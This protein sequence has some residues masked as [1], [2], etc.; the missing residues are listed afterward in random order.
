MEGPAIHMLRNT[1]GRAQFRPIQASGLV[2]LILLL[3]CAP[4]SPEA[5]L[6]GVYV[7]GS[8]TSGAGVI[9]PA[10]WKGARRIDLPVLDP[11]KEGAALAVA[12]TGTSVHAVGYSTNPSG[13]SVPAHWENGLRRDLPV[14]DPA[15]DGIATGIA[16]E[17]GDVY[18]AGYTKDSLGV[19][20][21]AS[22]RT[23]TA[24]TSRSPIRRGAASPSISR[25][26]AE[27]ST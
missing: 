7:A 11:S 20:S 17:G 25:S 12:V 27:P 26:T 22:G 4:R 14:I 8:T 15:R 23:G 1:R 10:I 2:I 16:L 6:S 19:G 21:P 5:E 9:V 18:I 24:S 13:V 3:S